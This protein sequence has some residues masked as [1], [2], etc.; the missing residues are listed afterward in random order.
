MLDRKVGLRLKECQLL[1]AWKAAHSWLQVYMCK[2]PS[3][4]A[5]QPPTCHAGALSSPKAVGSVLGLVLAR[6]SQEHNALRAGRGEAVWGGRV[7]TPAGACWKR[8]LLSRR[9]YAAHAWLLP[10]PRAACKPLQV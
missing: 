4:K 7:G 1:A 6:P 9:A 5:R 3:K 2:P 8:A 10:A